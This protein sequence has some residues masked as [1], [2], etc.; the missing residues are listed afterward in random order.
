MEMIKFKVGDQYENVKGSFTVLSIDKDE[1][2]IRW[3]NGE[4]ITTSAMLQ[5]QIIRRMRREEEERQKAEAD[6]EKKKKRAAKKSK[7]KTA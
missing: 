4:E 6:A 7:K 5:N 1:M 3:E 2:R